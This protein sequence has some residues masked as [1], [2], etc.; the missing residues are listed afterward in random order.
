MTESTIFNHWCGGAVKVYPQT[1]SDLINQSVM[2][3]FAE[4]PLAWP[5]S[6]NNSSVENNSGGTLGNNSS[7]ENNSGGSLENNSG[8]TLEN[9]RLV[10]ILIFAHM[11]LLIRHIYT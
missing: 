2:E 5:G 11:H 9:E 6:A 1:I 7:V 8:G 3:V 4:Q 10:L